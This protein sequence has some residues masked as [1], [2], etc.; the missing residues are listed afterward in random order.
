MAYTTQI[1]VNGIIYP[2]THFDSTAQQID[3]AVANMGGAST[4]QA[5]LAALGA[6][7]RPNLLVN[8]YCQINQKGETTYS[9][10]SAIPKPAFD[11]FKV[12]SGSVT[13]GENDLTVTGAGAGQLLQTVEENCL[14]TGSTYTLSF[15]VTSLN[16]EGR[17]TVFGG[18]TQALAEGLNVFTFVA[19]S[20]NYMGIYP[21]SYLNGSVT[22][23][24]AFKL[25][26]GPSQTL[27]YQDSTGV[28]QLLPQPDSKYSAQLLECQRYVLPLKTQGRYAGSVNSNGT[29]GRF[30]IPTPVT[31]RVNPTVENAVFTAFS[32]GSQIS[33]AKK[34]SGTAALPNG[35]EVFFNGVSGMQS[36]GVIVVGVGTAGFLS[37][38]I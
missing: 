29:D 37:A 27:A 25:E 8:G 23:K 4:P 1:E 33:L 38:E 13:I 17:T 18:T 22:F 16:G 21:V 24:K 7:V 34:I 2:V 30:F 9:D 3:D 28:W 20:Q 12:T 5:A 31:M 6:G 19:D 36:N 15:I 32:G 11:G 10:D 26:E 14:K 35:I